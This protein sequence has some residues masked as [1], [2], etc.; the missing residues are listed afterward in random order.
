MPLT[1]ILTEE[2]NGATVS[3][4]PGVTP[5]VVPIVEGEAPRYD[6][7]TVQQILA[8]ARQMQARHR[9]TLTAEDVEAL[10][11]E[12]GIEP[13]F[14]RRALAQIEAQGARPAI[15]TVP[16]SFEVSGRPPTRYQ[17]R[18]GAVPALVYAVLVTLTLGW[19]NGTDFSTFGLYFALPLALLFCV[20][21]WR[22]SKWADAL[23]VS[24]LALI[25]MLLYVAIAAYHH[26]THPGLIA[27]G[28]LLTIWTAAGVSLGLSALMSKRSKSPKPQ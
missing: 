8:L 11:H 19:M 23:G 18:R 12:V 22:K 20:G 4:L 6:A 21:F 10:G 3:A 17:R 2:P 16:R 26:G 7:Q 24:L 25:S 15:E 14:L 13:E 5:I 27:A 28:I 1:Q 9:E